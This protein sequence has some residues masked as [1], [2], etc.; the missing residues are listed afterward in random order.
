[1]IRVRFFKEKEKEGESRSKAWWPM[2]GKGKGYLLSSQWKVKEKCLFTSSPPTNFYLN[3]QFS[4][5]TLRFY[6]TMVQGHYSR[7]SFLPLIYK[8]RLRISM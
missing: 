4:P 5:L 2:E 3:L 6:F 1:M 8:L 7:I